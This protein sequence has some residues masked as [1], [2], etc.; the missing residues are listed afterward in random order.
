MNNKKRL[1]WDEI[2]VWMA[3]IVSYPILFATLYFL[4]AWIVS[5]LV[6]IAILTAITA[7]S[8]GGVMEEWL[9]DWKLSRGKKTKE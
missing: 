9:Y 3:I 1:K 7:T 5:R 6:V 4:A 2:A 8:F